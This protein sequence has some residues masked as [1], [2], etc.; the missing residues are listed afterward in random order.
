MSNHEEVSVPSHRKYADIL[1]RDNSVGSLSTDHFNN[2]SFYEPQANPMTVPLDFP[3][4]SFSGST[5]PLSETHHPQASSLESATNS[6][7]C[8]KPLTASYEKCFVKVDSCVD[9]PASKAK[10]S[11]AIIIRPP[12]NSASSLGVNTVS[13]RNMTCTDN[14]DFSG[15]LSKMEEPYIPVISECRELYSDTS[16]LNGLWQRNDR[17]SVES[18]STR[19]D[20][21][22][23]NEMGM[24][25]AD[26]LLKATPEL[27]VP[28]LNVEDGYTF[29]PKSTEA[30]LSMDN[31]SETFDYYNPAVD[32]PCWKGATTSHF[33]PFEVSEALSPCN[34]TGQFKP[35]DGFNLQGPHSFSL[36]IDDA[37]I[38]SSQK[39]NENPEYHKNMCG[40]HDLLPSRKR[41]SVGNHPSKEQKSCNAFEAGPCCPKLSGGD[42][43]QFSA[44]INQQKINHLQLNSSRSDSNL[45]PSRAM[46]PSFEEMKFTS[47]RKLLPGVGVEVTGNSVNDVL[48]HDSFR[49]TY[50]LTEK[51]SCSSLSGDDA[52][53]KLNKGVSESAPKIDVH[54]LINT[55][56]D[57]SVLLLSHCSD[58]A[59][60]LKEQDHETLTHV[61]GNL[62]ACLK[63]VQQ[64]TEQDSSHFLE[65]LPDL[66]KVFLFY[67]S[68]GYFIKTP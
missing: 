32:S 40:E 21:F 64:R 42:S 7:N 36:N 68:Y 51:V 17:L 4:I 56:Q 50:R 54:M 37:I 18:S 14:C 19:K 58:D 24:K 10:S 5:S 28:N 38:V 43:N 65:E 35:L 29:S 25:D 60:C 41:P 49:E 57:L 1:G 59:F 44:D 39:P 15:H 55:V 31:T 26:N 34:P 45:E 16:K 47:E 30:V 33:S 11:P 2:K 8:R 20:D 6:W 67:I 12:A 22:L 66:N 53:T 52:P 9:D 3:R 48:G 23:N 61:I 62:E 13:L 27:Q 46:Q 63:K